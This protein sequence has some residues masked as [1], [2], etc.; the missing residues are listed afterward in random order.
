MSVCTEFGHHVQ[1]AFIIHSYILFYQVH[2]YIDFGPPNSEQGPNVTG[3]FF[4]T[5]PSSFIFAIR[6]I[7]V[8]AAP[9]II[10]AN[11]QP[12]GAPPINY[13]AAPQIVST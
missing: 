1:E 8:Q 3:N 11:I 7:V 13:V 6:F 2:V 4:S 9:A 5:F 12:A 10:P